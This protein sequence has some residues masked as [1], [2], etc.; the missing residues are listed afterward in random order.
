MSSEVAIVGGGF[1][2]NFLAYL[3]ARRGVRVSVYE[4]HRK[5]G[6]PLHCAGIISE[7]GL[8]RLGILGDVVKEGAVLSAYRCLRIIVD[9]WIK[10]FCLE[11][12]RLLVVDRP[13]LDTIVF[14]KASNYGAEYYLGE[15]VREISRDGYFRVGGRS[16][17]AKILVDAEGASRRLIRG[18]LNK[19]PETLPALQ[20]DLNTYASNSEGIIEVYVNV[21]DFFSW[22][23]PIGE[24]KIRVG[25]ASK[26]ILDKYRF[27]KRL[28]EARYGK[29]KI[30]QKFGGIVN[31]GG[32]IDRLVFRRIAVVGDAAG[33]TKPTTGGG[34][35][36]G[37]LA[38]SILAKVIDLNLRGDINLLWYERIWKKIFGADLNFMLTIRK[39]LY[40][41]DPKIKLKLLFR[42]IPNIMP[43]RFDYD[44]Q[45]DF[46][47]RYVKPI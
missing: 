32:I 19:F 27:L 28:A 7:R 4:E 23:V 9:G 21:P 24:N 22:V 6:Y 31:V 18:F 33:Q 20:M 45:L 14:E 11:S 8:R 10:I 44:F 13:L 36:W 25:V 16:H 35:V 34:V 1:V 17:K 42:L 15:K 12:D 43:I 38:A 26:Y 40:L 47:R 5:I 39:M 41:G 37:G 30:I 3:L 46:I 29:I 2:G